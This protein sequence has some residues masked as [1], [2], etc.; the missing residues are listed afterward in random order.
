MPMA[1]GQISMSDPKKDS[2]T[3]LVMVSTKDLLKK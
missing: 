2:C 3:V 1:M